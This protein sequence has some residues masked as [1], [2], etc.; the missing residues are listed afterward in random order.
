MT[1]DRED[2]DAC[3]AGPRLGILVRLFRV[4]CSRVLPCQCFVGVHETC[5]GEVRQP[6]FE[7][8]GAITGR[9]PASSS[10]RMFF[11][12]PARTI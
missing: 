1:G 3:S 11:G 5:D 10:A 8:L 4:L 2:G 12:S 9:R 7:V 6:F